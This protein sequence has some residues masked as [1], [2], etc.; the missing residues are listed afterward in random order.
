MENRFT[1]DRR[2]GLIIACVGRLIESIATRDRWQIARNTT[3]PLLEK[4]LAG[5]FDHRLFMGEGHSQPGSKGCQLLLPT[6]V[7]HL[8][9]ER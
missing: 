8:S 6:A 7:L 4:L 3:G 5:Q 2:L 9:W 1:E